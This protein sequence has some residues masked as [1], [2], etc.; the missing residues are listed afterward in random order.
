MFLIRVET[1][2]PD[3]PN[4]IDIIV[5]AIPP[6]KIYYLPSGGKVPNKEYNINKPTP[7]CPTPGDR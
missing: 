6:T 1:I 5:V 2:G 3:A 4:N 7:T